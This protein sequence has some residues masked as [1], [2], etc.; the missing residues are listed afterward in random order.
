MAK[1]RANRRTAPGLIRDHAEFVNS[2]KTLRGE[3]NP[4]V[5]SAGRLDD[6]ESSRLRIDMEQNGIEYVVISF[7]TP[8]AWVTKNGW[9]YKVSETFTQTTSN[10]QGLLYMLKEGHH[11]G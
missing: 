6:V 4:T 9:T 1:A 11:E 2:S 3:C 5:I 10:H 8:I 7:D